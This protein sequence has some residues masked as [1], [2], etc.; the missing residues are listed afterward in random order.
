MTNI[1]VKQIRIAKRYS[2]ALID[3][4]IATNE[5][6]KIYD[7]LLFVNSTL[8][9]STDLKLFLEN[10]VITHQDKID[11]INQIFVSHLSTPVVNFLM[12]LIENNRF[13]AFDSIV[14]QYSSKM[15]EINNVLKAK[16]V[17]AVELNEEIKNRLIEKLEAKTA[18]KVIADYEINTDIIAGIIIEINDKTIDTSLKTKLNSIKKQLI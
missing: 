11:V 18:K 16:I 2:E 1:D 17:S 10:P 12:L 9:S 7:E 13:D 8:K 14:T 15:D 6:Q 5:V 4:A 3:S